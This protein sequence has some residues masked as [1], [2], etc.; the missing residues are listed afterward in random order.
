MVN[1]MSRA[2]NSIDQLERDL[3]IG[4]HQHPYGA[5]PDG[6]ITEVRVEMEA[7]YRRRESEGEWP[8]M[9]PAYQ[10]EAEAEAEARRRWPASFADRPGGQGIRTLDGS[11][12]NDELRR[13]MRGHAAGDLTEFS[14]AQLRAALD[15]E[16]TIMDGAADL[17][18]FIA[19]EMGRRGMDF[20]SR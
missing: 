4:A 17:A 19:Q 11:H 7:E 6:L 12:A 13:R 20:P 14:D 2:Q 18:A 5:D 1:P 10:R 3:K 15:R 8:C 16:R 9:P